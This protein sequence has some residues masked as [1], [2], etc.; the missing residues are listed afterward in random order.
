MLIEPI[1]DGSDEENDYYDN[2][3]G[4]SYYYDKEEDIYH[5]SS[6][7]TKYKV[8]VTKTNEEIQSSI[9]YLPGI[10]TDE[11]TLETY[12][13]GYIAFKN[14]DSTRNGWY[15]LNGNQTSIP[16]KYEIRDIKDNKIILQVSNDDENETYDAN[17]KYEMNFMILDLTGKKLLQTTA[18]DIYDNSYLVKNGNKKMVLMDKDLNVISNEYDKI[19]STMQMDISASYCSYY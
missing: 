18:L 15:D 2:Y 14:E 12:S 1:Y 3:N 13:N 17:K 9:V 7:E 10:D 5:V 16:S 4:N 6:Y 11:C 8:T 19:I